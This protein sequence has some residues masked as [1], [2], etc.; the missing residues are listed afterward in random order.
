M[1]LEDMRNH[2][3][4]T[5][6]WLDDRAQVAALIATP[7]P[8]HKEALATLSEQLAG[9]ASAI[10]LLLAEGEPG[11]FSVVEDLYGHQ[12]GGES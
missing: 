4:A 1:T 7:Y 11:A 10:R 9:R 3:R 12:L 2:L 8:N 5:A 6:L